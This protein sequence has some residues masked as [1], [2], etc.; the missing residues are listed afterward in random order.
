MLK[1]SVTFW[2]GLITFATIGTLVLLRLD[3]V[4]DTLAFA[5]GVAALA[6]SAILFRFSHANPSRRKWLERYSGFALVALIGAH[7][8]LSRW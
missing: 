7:L 5:V 2:Y 4:S 3:G 8:V 6:P 1:I